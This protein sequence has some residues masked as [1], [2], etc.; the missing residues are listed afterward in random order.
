LGDNKTNVER[1]SSV[2]DAY[3]K[4]V[5]KKVA[6]LMESWTYMSIVSNYKEL[7]SYYLD[8]PT[9]ELIRANLKS[10][11][12]FKYVENNEM[13]SIF[14]IDE[15]SSKHTWCDDIDRAC[16]LIVGT[17]RTFINNN[18]L[19]SEKKVAY[20]IFSKPFIPTNKDEFG[21]KV[22]RI[23]IDDQSENPEKKLE[24]IYQNAVKGSFNENGNIAASFGS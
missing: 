2:S 3:L 13:V 12:R 19:H 20:L 16:S 22:T 21:L 24:V 5:H 10:S 11:E 7:F 4:S 9:E 23:F 6:H 15:K 18:Q 8:K 17:R 14:E 1:S